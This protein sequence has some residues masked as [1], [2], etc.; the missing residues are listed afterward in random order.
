MSNADRVSY[1]YYS[2]HVTTNKRENYCVRQRRC[3]FS[4]TKLEMSACSDEL[5]KT[6]IDNI[7]GKARSQI[8]DIGKLE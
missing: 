6:G 5:Q 7:I 3:H 8:I 1:L 2:R 4:G